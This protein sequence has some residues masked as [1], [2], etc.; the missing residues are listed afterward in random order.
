[1]LALSAYVLVAAA[2][3]LAAD[4]G[5]KVGLPLTING[6]FV[7]DKVVHFLVVGGFA[8]VAARALRDFGWRKASALKAGMAAAAILA[9]V[10]ELTNLLTPHRG[11][12]LLDLVADYAGVIVFAAIWWAAG[13]VR[14]ARS[15][16]APIVDPLTMVSRPA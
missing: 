13:R 16:P 9:T 1:M 12:S 4:F 6:V 11:F 3:A 14:W 5:A 2:W 7:G 10:E 8:V 15:R